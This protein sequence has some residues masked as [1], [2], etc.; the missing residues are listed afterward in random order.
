MKFLFT[1]LAIG[2]LS[3]VSISKAD[4]NYT[5]RPIQGIGGCTLSDYIHPLFPE[6][7]QELDKAAEDC[8]KKK[9]LELAQSHCS[10]GT[11][12]NVIYETEKVASKSTPRVD[13]GFDYSVSYAASLE[14]ECL[15][16]SP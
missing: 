9:S 7:V 2:T 6:K 16:P 10:S 4:T 8:A 3:F 1:V 14:A 12:I 13:K 5:G 15:T 11:L